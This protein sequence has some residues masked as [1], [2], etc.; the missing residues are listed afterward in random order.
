VAAADARRPAVI[1]AAAVFVAADRPGRLVA[2]A[3][4]TPR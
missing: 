1:D 3:G 4:R 2:A